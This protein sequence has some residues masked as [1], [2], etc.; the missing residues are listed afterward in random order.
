MPKVTDYPS[1]TLPLDDA[2][3]VYVVQGGNSRKT[4][5][6]G[7][8]RSGENAFV[9]LSGTSTGLGSIPDQAREIDVIFASAQYAAGQGINFQ[10][11]GY[12]GHTFFTARHTGNNGVTPVVA[13]QNGDAFFALDSD[14]ATQSLIGMVSFKRVGSTWGIT[15][16][17]RRSPTLMITYS[18]ICSFGSNV[19]NGVGLFSNAAFV[20]GSAGVR[21]RV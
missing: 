21:W 17:L 2:D 5:M 7:V 19:L 6:A 10:F 15:G 4:T 13:G 1:A 12:T 18:G 20:G 11:T 3:V 9:T 14:A 8:G 16:T